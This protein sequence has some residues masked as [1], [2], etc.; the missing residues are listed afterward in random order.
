LTDKNGKL[1]SENV[2]KPYPKNSVGLEVPNLEI[3]SVTKL[4]QNVMT[5]NVTQD[6]TLYKSTFQV[7]LKTDKV[8]PYVWLEAIGKSQNKINQ[9][10]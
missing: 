2:L 9:N 6:V 4:T 1:L 3:V 5:Q 10:K 8:A 7:D